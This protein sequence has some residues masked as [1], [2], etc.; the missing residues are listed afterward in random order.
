MNLSTYPPLVG[1]VMI[2]MVDIFLDD[3]IDVIWMLE[4]WKSGVCLDD[5]MDV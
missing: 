2:M 1:W 5:G 4:T 3:G